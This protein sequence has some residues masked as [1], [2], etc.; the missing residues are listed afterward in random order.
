MLVV[1]LAVVATVT[2][3]GAAFAGDRYA[4]QHLAFARSTPDQLV[5]AMQH[6]EFYADYGDATVLFSGVVAGQRP[7]PGGV[8]I[9][10]RT[11]GIYSLTCFLTGDPVIPVGAVIHLAALGGQ[12]QRVA[13]GVRLA[14][15]AQS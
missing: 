9:V 7:Q 4:R 11:D 1:S 5:S 12:A 10:L 3:A 2:V 8:D 6:D 14:G 13:N 15:C